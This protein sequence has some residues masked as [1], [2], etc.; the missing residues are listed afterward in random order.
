MDWKK[1]Y[2]EGKIIIAN[3]YTTANAVHQCSKIPKE[4]RDDFLEWLFDY[5]WKKLGLPTPDKVIY[6]CQPPEVSFSLIQKRC[7]ETGAKKDIHEKDADHLYKSYEAALY[8]SEKYGW[9]RIDV[10]DGVSL[11][12]REDIHRE[13]IQKVSDL[14]SAKE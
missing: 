5:E 4:K 3:R 11:R 1:D 14:L 6:L 9:D 12:T 7:D 8:V 13:V 10:S 2:D